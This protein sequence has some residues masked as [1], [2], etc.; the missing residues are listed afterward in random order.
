[1]NGFGRVG[2]GYSHG[3]FG[4]GIDLGCKKLRGPGDG[5]GAFEC[6][7]AGIAGSEEIQILI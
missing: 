3:G 1:L 4:C 7:Y 5:G 2:L 6:E